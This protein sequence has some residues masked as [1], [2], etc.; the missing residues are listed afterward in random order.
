MKIAECKTYDPRVD[1]FKKFFRENEQ[2]IVLQVDKK[3]D[4]IIEEKSVYLEKVKQA[5]SDNFKEVIHYNEKRFGL[6]Q[7]SS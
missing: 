4:L 1:V 2:L 5:L 7:N 6:V 3:V